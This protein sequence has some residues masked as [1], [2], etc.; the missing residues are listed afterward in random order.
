MSRIEQ[1]LR[2]MI[3][4]TEYTDAPQSRI[5]AILYAIANDLE[6]IPPPYT[7]TPLSRIEELLLQ[8]KDKIESE[9]LQNNSSVNSETITLG[10]SIYMTAAAEGG[11]APYTYAF[12]YKQ[13]SSTSWITKG[14]EYDTATTANFK[15]SNTVTYDVRIG[16]RDATGLTITKDFAV[17]VES[18][19]NTNEV[20]GNGETI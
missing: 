1:T 13:Q 12:Y 11:T 4:G 18:T 2:A 3:D 8:L 15:P 9:F 16:V 5:E 19:N 14:A 17:T 7:G 6:E 20:G 10:D